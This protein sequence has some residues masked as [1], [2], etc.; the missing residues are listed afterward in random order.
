MRRLRLLLAIMLVAG[1]VFVPVSTAQAQECV[2]VEGHGFLD[3]GTTGQG[4]MR[5]MVDGE[6]QAVPMIPTG[7]IE[8]GENMVDIR[9]VMFFDQGTLVVVEHSFATP[10]AEGVVFFDSTL[11]V[12]K[13]GSGGL[14]WYGIADQNAGFADIQGISGEICFGR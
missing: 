1:F 5:L 7:A 12:K 3:F 10:I 9:F 11:D 8:I 4:K 14:V 2:N 6:R 13:G